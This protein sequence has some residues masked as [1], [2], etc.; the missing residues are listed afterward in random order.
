MEA[1]SDEFR[2]NLGLEM[3]KLSKM[4][5][6]NFASTEFAEALLLYGR[7]FYVGTERSCGSAYIRESDTAK[8]SKSHRK[9]CKHFSKF[10]AD[11]SAPATVGT[12][13]RLRGEGMDSSA[14]T[15]ASGQATTIAWLTLVFSFCTSQRSLV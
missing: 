2:M 9:R 8:V 11:S 14:R 12:E 6:A 5:V 10:I 13:Q 15:L 4:M 3:S 1:P 7:V